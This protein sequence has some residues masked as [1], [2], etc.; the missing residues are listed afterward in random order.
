MSH[1]EDPKINNDVETKEQLVALLEKVNN[2]IDPAEKIDLIN[3]GFRAARN[4]GTEDPE[5]RKIEGKLEA[6]H[7][8][9][10]SQGRA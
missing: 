7:W 2:S 5:V 10:L 1:K 3:K 9:I 8:T 6:I 4:I